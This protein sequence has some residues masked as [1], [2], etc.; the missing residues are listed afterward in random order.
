MEKIVKT[1]IM[2]Q[3]VYKLKLKGIQQ[4]NLVG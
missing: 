4:L 3:F 2:C 1:S